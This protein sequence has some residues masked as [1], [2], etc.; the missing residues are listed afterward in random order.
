MLVDNPLVSPEK[1]AGVLSP[2]TLI[3]EAEAG[4]PTA[5]LTRAA[6]LVPLVP[7]SEENGENGGGTGWRLLFIRRTEKVS[8][9]KGQIAFPGGHCDAED[10]DELASALREA[11]EELGIPPATVRILGRLPCHPTTST[12]FLIH[13]FVGIVDPDIA[14]L[15]PSRSE[16]AEIFTA[17]LDFFIKAETYAFEERRW[18]GFKREFHSYQYGDYDIWGATAAITH[19]FMNR[20]KGETAS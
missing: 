19:N 11:E 9:H 6:V 5:D 1:I 18:E 20:L 3:E 12:G 13:P 10:P 14:A 15:I 16:V 2:L 4:F 8:T 17:P 7:E